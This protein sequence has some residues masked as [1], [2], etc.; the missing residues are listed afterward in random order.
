MNSK[1][2]ELVSENIKFDSQVIKSKAQH[3]I[4]YSPTL[5]QE[6]FSNALLDRAVNDYRIPSA[7]ERLRIFKKKSAKFKNSQTE[8][9]DLKKIQ[10]SQLQIS[11][12]M[13]HNESKFTPISYFK[14]ISEEDLKG[15]TATTTK[16]NMTKSLDELNKAAKNVFLTESVVQDSEWDWDC[17]LIDELSE[18]T[19]RWM[20]MKKIERDG[21][22]KML[23]FMLKI[24]CLFFLNHIF[25]SFSETK[26]EAIVF[27]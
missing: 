12:T 7:R 2:L 8:S 9:E 21:N 3:T 20:V 11:E 13:K 14:S 6:I 23:N 19:A 22:W 25:Y 16:T 17:Q 5:T 1:M 24:I 15:N 10:N 26:R 18:N 27:N 4:P